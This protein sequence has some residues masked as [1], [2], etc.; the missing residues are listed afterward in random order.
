MPLCHTSRE[1]Y[2]TWFNLTKGIRMTYSLISHQCIH[3]LHQENTSRCGIKLPSYLMQQPLLLVQTVNFSSVTPLCTSL[4]AFKMPTLNNILLET[5]APVIDLTFRTGY[6]LKGK[7]FLEAFLIP[8]RLLAW[9]R[10]LTATDGSRGISGF[11]GNSGSLGIFGSGPP[12]S[13]K[14]R[15]R[16]QYSLYYLSKLRAPR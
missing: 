13:T 11:R 8:L 15:I 9:M 1:S 16:T 6:R 3:Y 4:E 10:F 2:P 12:F 5:T 14:N 7:L